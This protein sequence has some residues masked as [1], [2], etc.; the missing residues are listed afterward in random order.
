MIEL[1]YICGLRISEIVSLQSSQID[2]RR[3][4]LRILGKGEKMRVACPPPW[5]M[6]KLLRCLDDRIGPVF[7]S[8]RHRRRMTRAAF[9]RMLKER[10]TAAAVPM[11]SA[12]ALRHGFAIQLCIAGTPLPVVQQ[13]LRHADISTTMI[14]THLLQNI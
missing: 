8:T 6:A 13:L 5:L 4:E 2:R 10:C 14:Y 12:H 3:G 11:L 1:G 9:S 7:I